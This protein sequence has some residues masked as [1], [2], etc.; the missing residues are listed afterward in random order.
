MSNKKTKLDN[1]WTEFI[2]DNSDSSESSDYD[3]DQ[4]DKSLWPKKIIDKEIHNI[5]DLLYLADLYDENELCT[6]N[7]DLE[8]ISKLKEPLNNL[9]N[10][11]GLDNIKQNIID[12]IIYFLAN[13]NDSED[14]LHTVI[15]GP[16]GVGKT[17]LGKIIGDIYF[18][19][20]I[21]KG[22]TTKKRKKSKIK[23]Y[24][25]KIVKRSDL[26]GK[27]VGHTAAK[28][29]QVIDDCDGGV[30]FIDEAYSL[31]NNEGR[32]TFSKECIDTINQN[33]TENKK[34]LLCIIAGY[35]ESLEKCFFAYNEGLARRFTFRYDIDKYSP[36][37]LKL[38]FIKLI[39][40]INWSLDNNI[41]YDFFKSNYEK[42]KHMAGDMETL[43]FQ[44]K[45][46]HGKRVLGK[47]DNEKRILNQQDINN[48]L[49]KFIDLRKS[50]EPKNYLNHLYV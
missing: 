16:P 37:E 43:L 12:N 48:G 4:Y 24:N 46:E 17:K 38:I 25:F 14:M 39:E 19:L 2:E 41:N 21:L 15:T 42:F 23:S 45:I 31:G 27:Y 6:Y 13:I 32:D 3:F 1:D 7:I 40:E 49:K 28:T 10:M 18:N 47:P 20:G 9:K 29:Q 5:D 34:N 22:N 44:C 30:L 8:K 26:I 11:I 36:Q 50:N 35:K 33:L